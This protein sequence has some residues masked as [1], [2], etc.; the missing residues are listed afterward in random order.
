MSSTPVDA[1]EPVLVGVEGGAHRR[2]RERAWRLVARRIDRAP[3]VLRLLALLV[4]PAGC[5]LVALAIGQDIDYDLLNYHFYDAW[6]FLNGRDL[7]DMFAANTQSLINPLLDVPSY[8]LIAH[9]PARVDAFVVGFEQGLSPLVVY[10]IARRVVGVRSLSLA[11]AVAAAVAGGFV[12]ELG[13][14]MGD[15]IVALPLLLGALF[16]VLAVQ[17][18]R[19]AASAGESSRS[20]VDT[21]VADGGRGRRLSLAIRWWLASGLAVGIGAGLKFAELPEAAGLVLGS[22]AVLGPWRERLRWFAASVAG[23]L[24]GAL[25]TAGYWS[26]FLW[27]HYGDPFAFT[28]GSL[29]IFHS[30]YVPSSGLAGASDAP[31]T[32]GKAIYWPVYWLFHPSAVSEN[33][34]REASIPI[35]YV[36]LAALLVLVCLRGAVAVFGA[37]RHSATGQA[38]RRSRQLAVDERV[39]ASIDRYFIVTFAVTIALWEKVFDVY[40]YL[41]PLE[42][43]APIVIFAAGRRLAVFVRD[44]GRRRV[45]ARRVL[46]PLFVLI[47]VVCVATESPA[48]YWLRVGFGGQYFKLATPS[49][50]ENGKLDALVEF[51]P[52][53]EAFVMPLLHGRFVGIGGPLNVST[54]ANYRRIE[55][56]FSRIHHGGGDVIGYWLDTAPPLNNVTFLADIGDPGERQVGCV[57]ERLDIGNGY[58]SITFCRFT[59]SKT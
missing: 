35:A 13:N 45:L 42:L 34:L 39:N 28:G 16:A 8:L 46:A 52:N 12:S 20:G 31:A 21:G 36:L 22:A 25:A 19:S 27:R 11:A 37:L 7:L 5:G 59:L 26:Y 58:D 43:L 44:P 10:L 48:D 57:T 6:A 24:V 17:A 32:L 18:G 40:R 23:A 1:P 54:T 49:M 47:C 53:P 50:L 2:R 51:G 56:E 41:I 29:W 38:F 33:P 15:S 4:F 55:A 30:S 3:R 9:A 14:H